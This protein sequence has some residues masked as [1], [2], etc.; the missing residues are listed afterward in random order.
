VFASLATLL[1]L[2][3]GWLLLPLV[4]L[5]PGLFA[6]TPAGVEFLD[7]EGRPLRLA[8]QGEEPF[9]Q[10]AAYVE[11][12][13]ALVHA[14]LAAEDARFWSHPGLDWRGILRAAW[15][16]VRRQRIVSG[17]S[18]ITQQLVKQFE[19]RPRTFGAKAVEAAK[20]LRLEQ[21][22]D[23]QRILS[24]YLN[25]VDYGNFT[26]GAPAAA[27]FYFGKRVGDLSPA[28][29]A[30]L[31][32]LPQ[33]PSRLNPLRRP[34]R[35]GGRQRWILD[36]MLRRGWLTAEEHA[37][38][39][40]EP[41][42]FVGQRQFAAP[43]FVDFVLDAS[44]AVGQASRL[45]PSSEDIGDRRDAC[46]T[47]GP[48]RTTLDLPLNQF[49]EETLRQHLA[50]LRAQHVHNGAIVV[51]EN[52][53]G[54]VL[55]MVG[56]E[57]FFAAGSG[58]VNGAWAARSAG[59]TFKPFTYALA[60]ERGATAAS[61]IAD[62]PASF[63]T[64]T[65]VF[66]PVNYD[67]RCRG[68]VSL[69]EALACS[70]NIPAVRTLDSVGGP[71]PLLERLRDCGLTTLT[72]SPAHYGLGLT[73]GNAETRLLELANAY[74][75]LAR[76]GEYRPWQVLR[77]AADD[78]QPEFRNPKAEM[79]RR[80][81][82]EKVRPELNFG[83]EHSGFGLRV[84]FGPRISDFGFRDQSSLLPP[85]PG[86]TPAA[87]WLVADILSDNDARAAAFGLDSALR[88]DFPV[89]CKT[90]TSTGFRDNW[91][92][93][94]TP[95]FT[96]GVWVGNFDGSPMQDVSGVTGAAPILHE[97]FVHLR[98]RFGTTWYPAP[99]GLMELEVNRLTGKRLAESAASRLAVKA[100][101]LPP[102]LPV[103]ERALDYDA[104]G[105]VRLPAEYADWFATGENPFRSVA[106]VEAAPAALRI[107]FPL[108]GTTFFLDGDLP[109]HGRRITLAAQ[110][111]SELAW[112]S[113][114]LRIERAG[115]RQVASLSPGRHELTVQDSA[116][117]AAATTW[118]TVKEP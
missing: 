8:R 63:A 86:F 107:T 19:P 108:P 50:T 88:F 62:V 98:R 91:A 52:R 25:R 57:D 22:W 41:L 1:L 76:L 42:R 55:A 43:H 79:D 117:G 94:Y 68:P 109:D 60:L 27:R 3:L 16:L 72:E 71:A 70:L 20:A 5:P 110:G 11:F 46:P 97:L 21:V 90:G 7:R 99:V 45:S 102:A 10:R 101:F 15:Q 82:A 96:V 14:T 13:Q 85:R 39:T 89:A 12:P 6:A 31:A 112:R 118:L 100:K 73:I 67:R 40:N 35:A 61:V 105:R 111:G 80:V 53:S 115:H 74:A 18:T 87:A 36:Q 33:A 113:P 69:R 47:N 116:T 81:A 65:G 83:A 58:Q 38:A 54:G 114:T 66:S 92:F 49:A 64:A 48:V 26:L 32:A 17:G 34:E 104:L 59:S 9:Q 77:D 24:E 93:G 75:C 44:Q 78:P 95:E 28:E 84:S 103:V 23:K 2:L 30:L 37:R 51:L 4:P 106:V 56:S 29:C